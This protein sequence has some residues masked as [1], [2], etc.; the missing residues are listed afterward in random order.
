MIFYPHSAPTTH[1]FYIYFIPFITHRKRKREREL[2]EE[3]EK[4]QFYQKCAWLQA[5][6]LFAFFA[7]Y[8]VCT[9]RLSLLHALKYFIGI[10]DFPLSLWRF[11]SRQRL[12]WFLVGSQCGFCLYVH[13]HYVRKSQ[14][15]HL[16]QWKY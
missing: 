13:I 14:K 9:R 15:H 16:L 3:V 1:A 4:N 10:F 7:L 5:F 11:F 8:A 12:I 6:H 2:N